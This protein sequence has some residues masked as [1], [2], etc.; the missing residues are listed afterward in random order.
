MTPTIRVLLADDHDIVREGTRRLLERAEGLEVVGEAGD[1]EEA[2]RL[3]RQLQPDVVVMDVHMPLLNG[4]E[5]TRRIKAEGLP[6]RVLILSAYEDDEY[7]F[8]LLEAG[9][10]G[11]LLKT[12][13]GRELAQAIRAI[14][15]GQSVLDPQITGKVVGHLAGAHGA[16]PRPAGARSPGM[17]EALTER[18]LEVLQ[19]VADGLSNKGIAEALSISTYT[20][21]VHLRNIFGKMGV[22]SRTAAVTFALRQGWVR[23]GDQPRRDEP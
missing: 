1:G 20:V 2:L 14:Y 7:V 11:Y 3:V 21:Q 6:A 8:P 23:L 4:L 13:N 17:I 22:D 12:T 16:G 10:S 9:A 5:A 15:A 19:A 18:E